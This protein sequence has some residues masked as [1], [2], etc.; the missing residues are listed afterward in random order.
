MIRKAENK[1]L[2][3][4]LELVRAGLDELGQKYHESLLLK[5]VVNSF[6]LAPCFL[7]E[8]DGIIRGI[9]GFTVIKSSWD[10]EATLAD[11]LFYIEPEYRNI[12]N[13]SGLV[14]E[15]KGFA[16]TMNLPLRIEYL[17]SSDRKLHERLMRINGFKIESLVGYYGKR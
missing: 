16:D 1:D 17:V 15:A 9:A 5:K 6:H 8:I 12:V 10:G 3:K 4:V 11:Y 14:E 2:D 7:L 13:L